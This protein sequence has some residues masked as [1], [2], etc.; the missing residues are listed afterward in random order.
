MEKKKKKSHSQVMT[1]TV[2]LT[3]AWLAKEAFPCVHTDSQSQKLVWPTKNHLTEVH[4]CGVCWPDQLPALVQAESSHA[5]GR[6]GSGV[7]NG[8]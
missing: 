2:F 4:V 3:I 5:A 6:E 1:S 7:K 8:S